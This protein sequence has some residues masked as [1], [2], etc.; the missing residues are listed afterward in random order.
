MQID[1]AVS[2]HFP[3]LLNSWLTPSTIVGVLAILVP[4]LLHWNNKRKLRPTM[5]HIEG[6]FDEYGSRLLFTIISN[7][8]AGSRCGKLVISKKLIWKIFIQKTRIDYKTNKQFLNPPR[9]ETIPKYLI[10]GQ[11]TFITLLD[12]KFVKTDGIFKL[13]FYTSDGYCSN[14]FSHYLGKLFERILRPPD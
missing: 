7:N 9:G 10:K 14:N 1:S 8:P 12:S 6:I 5:S 13:T 4:L 2:I 3:N 11:E